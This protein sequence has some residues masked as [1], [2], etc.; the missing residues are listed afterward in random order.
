MFGYDN[1]K[2]ASF[3]LTD[4]GADNKQIRLFKADTAIEITAVSVV[5]RDAQGAGSAGNFTLLNYGTSGTAVAGT[6]TTAVG[7]TASADRLA[8]GVPSAAT[9]SDGTLSSGQWVVLDYQETG[10][11]VEGLVTVDI[12]YVNGVGA[13]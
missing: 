11:W 10:D 9:V 1:K 7:G 6:I 5:S 3:L 8:A 4:P 13:S 2:H 12:T